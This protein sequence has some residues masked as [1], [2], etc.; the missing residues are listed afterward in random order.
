MLSK[1]NY[2]NI[3]FT[4]IGNVPN[5][6]KFKNTLVKEP[7]SGDELASEIKNNIYLTVEP[8]GIITLRLLNA[9]Y[10]YYI[11]TVEEFPEYC[12]GFGVKFENDFEKKVYL[13]LLKILNF[14][15]I[16]YPIIHFRQTQCVKNSLISFV[17]LKRI[18]KMLQSK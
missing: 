18:K 2:K 15:D 3:K 8:S 17:M 11:L 4:Y 10:Q 14:T 1:P 16:L 7:L 13:K 12:D 6:I 5:E 9:D